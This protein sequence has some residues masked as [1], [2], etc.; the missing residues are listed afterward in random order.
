M[1]KQSI[2]LGAFFLLTIGLLAC[3]QSHKRMDMNILV[4]QWY[5]AASGA[6]EEWTLVGP[7]H[8]KGRG[9]EVKDRDTVVYEILELKKING[10]ITYLADVE[11]AMGQG[12]VDFPLVSHTSHTMTFINQKHD[13]PQ[14]LSYE[15]I[16]DDTLKVIVG[17][18]PLLED[19]EAM[20]FNYVRKK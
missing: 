16:S 18:Y 15:K 1:K 9:F 8:L 17:K 3:D 2:R 7:D 12:I 13:Y 19:K 10:T 11:E 4:G 20:V 5:D 14:V 6:H